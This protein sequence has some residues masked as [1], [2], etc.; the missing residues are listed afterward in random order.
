[1]GLL[2]LFGKFFSSPKQPE[3]TPEFDDDEDDLFLPRDATILIVDD[4][5]THVAACKKWLTDD[6]Y[7]TLSAFDGR[8]GIQSAKKEQPDL[9]LMD[10]VMP[11]INGFQATRFLKRQADTKHIPIILISGEEQSSGKIWAKK[12]GASSF[13]VKPLKKQT[14]LNITARVLEHYSNLSSAP[15]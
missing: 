10:I 14:L 5:K 2:S 11:N 7:N 1:M 6:G 4:S 15:D 3:I 12:L 9:I 8:E 13:L